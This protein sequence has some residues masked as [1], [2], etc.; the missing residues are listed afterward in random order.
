MYGAVPLK[1]QAPVA[2]MKAAGKLRS[3]QVCA[4]QLHVW[5]ALFYNC[6]AG[7]GKNGWPS[8]R[9]ESSSADG[10]GL[11]LPVLAPDLTVSATAE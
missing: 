9:S 2:E 10:A 7:D 11:H 8:S 5:T 4:D 6:R 1:N 3:R